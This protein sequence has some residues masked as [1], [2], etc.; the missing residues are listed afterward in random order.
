MFR[1]TRAFEDTLLNVVKIQYVDIQL[2][3]NHLQQYF[4]PPDAVASNNEFLNLADEKNNYAFI[5]TSNDLYI[6]PADR[7]DERIK[8]HLVPLQ[9]NDN[10]GFNIRFVIQDKTSIGQVEDPNVTE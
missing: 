9:A 3:E 4:L 6:V 10:Y 2:F 5:E 8:E 7:L 1:I